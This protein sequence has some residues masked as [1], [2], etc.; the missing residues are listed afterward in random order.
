MT[1]LEV[2]VAT[3]DR[4]LA[5]EEWQ[6]RIGAGLIPALEHVV[7]DDEWYRAGPQKLAIE[8]LKFVTQQE[9]LNL[10]VADK[11]TTLQALDRA[12]LHLGKAVDA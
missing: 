10:W 9:C 5:K 7:P 4:L 6:P 3:R 11:V 1:P 12:I 2:L 8:A